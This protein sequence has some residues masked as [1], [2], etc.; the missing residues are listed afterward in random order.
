VQFGAGM[1]IHRKPGEPV[2]AGESLFTL[3]TETPERIPAAL[4][5]L[6]GAWRVGDEAPV[7][8]PLIID[9]IT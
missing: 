1:R 5:E 8:R 2:A 9:R 3:Y 6:D 4:S 7:K